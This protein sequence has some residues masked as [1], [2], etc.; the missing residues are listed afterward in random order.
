MAFCL[1]PLSVVEVGTRQKH[2]MQLV[3]RRKQLL[4][5]VTDQNLITGLRQFRPVLFEAGKDNKV[6]LIHDLT[7][8]T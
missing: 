4:L 3:D 1:I 6:V 7:A 8:M 2:P 5:A